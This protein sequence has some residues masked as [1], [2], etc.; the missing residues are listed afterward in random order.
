MRGAP[1]ATPGARA[2]LAQEKRGR[3]GGRS[4]HARGS[5]LGR[6]GAVGAAGAEAGAGGGLCGSG[7]GS[8]GGMGDENAAPAAPGASL[9]L[10]K[11]RM[12][13]GREQ[14]RAGGAAGATRGAGGPS[15]AAVAAPL[16]AEAADRSSFGSVVLWPSADCEGASLDAAGCELSLARPRSSVRRT[17]RFFSGAVPAGSPFCDAYERFVGP[18]VERALSEGESVFVTAAGAKGSGKSTA[19]RGAGGVMERIADAAWAGA[20]VACEVGGYA[21]FRCAVSCVA[22]AITAPVESHV[23]GKKYAHEV[24]YD[25]LAR[26]AARAEGATHV[27]H[28]TQRLR[29]HPRFGFFLDGLSWVEAG[30][31]AELRALVR[32][33]AIA[34]EEED[35]EAAEQREAERGKPAASKRAGAAPQAMHFLLRIR[36]QLEHADGTVVHM[37]CSVADLQGVA[38]PQPVRLARGAAST[39]ALGRALRR[40]TPS[41]AGCVL[42]ARECRRV[43]PYDA[44][45]APSSR[46]RGSPQ[47]SERPPLPRDRPRTP[48]PLA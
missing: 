28:L 25:A 38:R 37:E 24:L 35:R 36:A 18:A 3:E 39:G 16:P 6:G 20:A 2:R 4:L 27:G 47:R 43:R 14:Q 32:Q 15:A 9:R 5:V 22:D 40:L 11:A 34:C 23:T 1:G 44:P 48:S 42:T 10:L 45:P 8:G 29:E 46:R 26:R 30:S 31:L 21:S 41:C 33:A 7:G 13:A 19:L 12:A 17:H